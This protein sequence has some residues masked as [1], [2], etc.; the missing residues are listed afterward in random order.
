MVQCLMRPRLVVEADNLRD[1]TAGVVVAEDEDVIEQLTTER[2]DEP[3][4]ERIH[5]GSARRRPDDPDA[6][7][8][9]GACERAAELSVAIAD[10]DLRSM[11]HRRV[12]GLLRAPRDGRRVGHRRVNHLATTK[13]EEE[14][15]EDLA[16]PLG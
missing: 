16:E 7:A 2:A 11:I 10:E 5:V 13:V 9:E 4:R 6:D 8:V 1:E 14:E 12:A 15:H 3:F